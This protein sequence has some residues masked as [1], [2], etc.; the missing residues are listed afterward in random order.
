[1]FTGEVDFDQVGQISEWNHQGA[2]P[3]HVYSGDCGVLKGSA[4]EFFPP[5]RDRTW[6]DY[7][8]PDICR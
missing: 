7:F 2:V 1:M 3:E 6:L 5:N 4:G 8:S